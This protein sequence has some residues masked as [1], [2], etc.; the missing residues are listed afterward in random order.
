MIHPVP[1]PPRTPRKP[2]HPL[3]SASRPKAKNAK[4]QKR[5]KVRTNGSPERDAFVRSLPCAACG[6]VGYSEVAHVGREGKGGSRKANADQTAPLCGPRPAGN[7]CFANYEGCHRASHRGQQ[8]FEAFYEVDLAEC[9]AETERAYQATINL[10]P[11]DNAL[12]V[13]GGATEN[14]P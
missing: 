1:K 13:R 6:V 10:T 7:R 12:I 14:T 2:R 4:R 11:V 5:E 8:T 9:A 3:Q